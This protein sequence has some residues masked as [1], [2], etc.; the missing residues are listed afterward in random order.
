[1]Y[2]GSNPATDTLVAATMHPSHLQK[3]PTVDCMDDP[4]A[5]ALGQLAAEREGV[6]LQILELEGNLDRAKRRV[7]EIDGETASLER[8]RDELKRRHPEPPR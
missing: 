8:V 4:V 1:M 7:A 2:D 5:D 6:V 3:P